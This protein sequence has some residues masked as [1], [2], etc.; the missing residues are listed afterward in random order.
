MNLEKDGK[1]G[2]FHSPE[3]LEWIGMQINQLKYV[4]YGEEFTRTLKFNK[5]LGKDAYRDFICQVDRTV[6]MSDDELRA[7]NLELERISFEVA[8]E[9][10][11]QESK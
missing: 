8:N 3:K 2:W 4:V 10:L 1:Y 9:I 7:H 6:L 5:E 11:K